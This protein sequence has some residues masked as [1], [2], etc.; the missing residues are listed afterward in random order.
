M[1]PLSKL[2]I[3]CSLALGALTLCLPPVAHAAARTPAAANP[4][5]DEPDTT[6]PQTTE[7]NCEL[8]NKITIYTNA[9]DDSHIALR[10]KKKTAAPDPGRHHHRPAPLRKSA[11]RPDLDRHPGQ[12]HAAGLQA[13]PPAGQRMQERRAGRQELTPS[14]PAERGANRL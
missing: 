9:D 11:L 8:N 10:W 4:D 7:F 6:G 13:E 12:G 14:R 5:A 2:S 1:S 3:A